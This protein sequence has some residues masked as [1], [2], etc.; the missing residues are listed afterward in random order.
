MQY[1]QLLSFL[2]ASLIISST[3]AQILQSSMVVDSFKN[4]ILPSNE[5]EKVIYKKADNNDIILV[6]NFHLT[7]DNIKINSGHLYDSVCISIYSAQ[8]VK[9]WEKRLGDDEP[10]RINDAAIHENS[11]IMI[12]D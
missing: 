7:A 11:L 9:K 2:I 10:F 1:R 6:R 12:G 5:P 4:E 3:R 8:G